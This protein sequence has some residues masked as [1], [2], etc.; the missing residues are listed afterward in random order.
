MR[1]DHTA[2]VHLDIDWERKWGC[3]CCDCL[4][5]M[6]KAEFEA[7]QR[8]QVATQSGRTPPTIKMKKRK[9]PDSSTER[10]EAE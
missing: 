1:C 7:E 2:L 6:D 4:G 9:D 3:L 5:F 8:A 10:W